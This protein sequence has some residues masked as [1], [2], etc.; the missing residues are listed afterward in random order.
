MS[1]SFPEGKGSRKRSA[2][3]AYDD[4][5]DDDYG[6]DDSNSV[7]DASH[8]QRQRFLL[9]QG[10]D[11][12]NFIENVCRDLIVKDKTTADIWM[13]FKIY[14]DNKDVAVCNDCIRELSCKRGNTSH[15][16]SHHKTCASLDGI[17]MTDDVL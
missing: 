13:H 11:S 16:R 12:F 2:A 3:A 6:S 10:T 17:N 1:A 8:P 5:D 7:G 9:Q 15:I 14:K 4:D